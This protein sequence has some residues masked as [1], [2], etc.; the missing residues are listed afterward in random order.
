MISASVKTLKPGDSVEL[1]FEVIAE[2]TAP[3]RITASY[4][5]T[6]GLPDVNFWHGRISA[7]PL[8]VQFVN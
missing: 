2:S 1:P 8:T 6:A 5:V 7:E 4:T 3:T